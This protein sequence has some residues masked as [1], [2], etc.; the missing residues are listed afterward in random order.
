MAEKS[1]SV[2][3]SSFCQPSWEESEVEGLS[4]RFRF[5]RGSRFPRSRKIGRTVDHL[6]AASCLFLFQPDQFQE[7]D[8][9]DGE[10]VAPGIDD[11]GRDDRQGQRDL[12]LQCRPLAR[13][14][15]HVDRAADLLD[16]GLD[17]VHADA[18]ARDVGD[19]R[20][21][22]EARQEDQAASGR[23]R[24]FARPV[25]GRAARG[26]GPSS[27]IRSALMPAPSSEISMLTC[28]PS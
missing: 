18:S 3:L 10:A 6:D 23:G 22:A 24:P 4:S 9:R 5:S 26:R 7:I 15:L 28:P 17:H 11:Q 13:R 2:P 16:V 25:R 8:L 12:D 21:R 19:L 1:T 20:G 14:A 27:L